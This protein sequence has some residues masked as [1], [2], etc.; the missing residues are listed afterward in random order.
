MAWVNECVCVCVQF[1]KTLLSDGWRDVQIQRKQREKLT[2]IYMLQKR[3][4]E[5]AGGCW[6]ENPMSYGAKTKN[7]IMVENYITNI[8]SS[9]HKV[10]LVSFVWKL[11]SQLK[12]TLLPPSYHHINITPPPPQ[13]P[14]SSCPLPPPMLFTTNKNS[15]IFA[16]LWH[17][18][19]NTHIH[20]VFLL[21]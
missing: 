11:G 15:H 2:H 20:T 10:Y 18:K 21:W 13:Q 8:T 3:R 7:K 17:T 6:I 19:K 14:S 1:A 12:Q 5:I 4:D 16:S 9:L